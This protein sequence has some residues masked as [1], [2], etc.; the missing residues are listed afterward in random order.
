MAI[1]NTK[2]T[3]KN[4]ALEANQKGSNDKKNKLRFQLPVLT[5]SVAVLAFVLTIYNIL[6]VKHYDKDNKQE[7]NQK[8]AQMLQTQTDNSQQ[9]SAL[10]QRFEQSQDKIEGLRKELQSA[11]QQSLYQEQDW[12]LLRVRYYLELA[13]INAHWSDNQQ[14]T[15]GLLQQADEVLKPLSNP[16][17]FEVR[18]A[19]AQEI[20][21]I[22]SLAKV[23]VTGLL[24]QLDAA[25]NQLAKLPMRNIPQLQQKDDLQEK[26][27]TWKQ[28]LKASVHSLSQLVVVRYNDASTNQFISPQ[29]QTLL[30]DSIYLN[31]QEAQWAVLANN[32][33]VFHLALTQALK[34]ASRVFDQNDQGAIALRQQI[35][36]LQKEDFLLEKPVI[37]KSL[38]LLNQYIASKSNKNGDKPQ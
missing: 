23:D 14:V 3:D 6:Q 26:A 9:V 37:E 27:A 35:E 20:G 30:R 2:S 12:L 34:T 36:I 1:E 21:Q 18:Q 7:F 8:F 22:N 25:Q 33:Q 28:K 32:S 19:I 15:L 24:S 5:L 17:L 11:L 4:K 16:A 10:H 31:L 38:S 13:Q 29:Y